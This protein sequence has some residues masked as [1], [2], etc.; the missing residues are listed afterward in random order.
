MHDDKL[1]ERGLTRH[2]VDASVELIRLHTNSLTEIPLS[3]A[4]P[5]LMA[6]ELVGVGADS[7]IVIHLPLTVGFLICVFIR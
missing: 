3:Y 2:L 1:S 6:D 4:L 5:L 7:P